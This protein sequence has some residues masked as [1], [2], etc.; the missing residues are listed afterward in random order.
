MLKSGGSPSTSLLVL[1]L[2][3]VLLGSAHSAGSSPTSSV[4][5]NKFDLTNQYTGRASGGDGSPAYRKVTQA[6]GRKAIADARDANVAYLRVA[7]PGFAPSAFQRPGDLDLWVK[8]PAAYWQLID[9]LMDDLEAAS[10]QAVFTFIWN[11]AQFPAMA[12][13]TVHDLLTNPTSRSAQLAERYVREFVLRYKDRKTI[14][15]Y[16]LTNE[17]NLG[18]DLDLVGRC[19]REQVLPLCEPKGNYTTEEMTG[20]TRHLAERIRSLDPSRPISSG[21]TVPRPAAEHLRAR[22]EWVTGKADFTLDTPAQLEKNLADIHAGL[23]MISV[24]LYPNE[25]NRR[26]GATDLRGTGLLD[27]V[28]QAANK[29][30]KPLFVGEFGDVDSM[31]G[32]ANTY[33]VRMLDRIA[34]LKVPY[35]A[36]WVWEFYQ[37]TPYTTRDNPHTA[38]SL[39]PGT[40]DALI[41]R[42]RRTNIRLGNSLPHRQQPDQVPPRVVLTWPLACATVPDTQTIFA[43]ASDDSGSVERVEFWLDNVLIAAD[44]A[45]P[46]EATMEVGG[47]KKG[48]HALIAKAFDQAN[49]QAEYHSRV[50]IGKPTMGSPCESLMR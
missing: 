1:A 11:P 27:V 13:E 12:G 50:I 14:L 33:T 23:D 17:L 15:F 47:F 39:E 42:I 10:M 44:P 9:N 49:N 19:R 3:C 46:Y 30:G 4:G 21:F 28:W 45:P 43:V 29:I 34:E 35:S 41:D 48:D 32:E 38:F 6:M 36:L 20:F 16:E 37:K 31:E 5:L 2:C 26:F 22:P 24:H 18:A 8:A 40:T 25:S 7:A